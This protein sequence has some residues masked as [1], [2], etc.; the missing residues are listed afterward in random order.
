MPT[1][2]VTLPRPHAA[3][4]QIR[5]EAKRH[6][7]VAL[8]RRSGKSTMGHELVV[9]TALDGQP[10]GWFGPTYKLLEESWRELKRILGPVVTLKSE[11]EHRLE[12][13]GGGT[14]ECW[15]MDT[16]DPARGRKYKRIVVDEAA[17]VPN[18]LDIWNQAL[19][20]TLADFAGESWWLSTPRGLNDFYVLY[21]RGQDELETDWQ[22]WQMPT[23]VNPHINQDELNAARREMPERDYAQEFEARFLQVEGAGVFRGVGAVSRLK[24][25]G[26]TR[27]H[28]HVF[29]VD[30]GRSND[31]TV[32]TVIDAT[33]ME[34]RV[35]DRYSQ[36]EWEFQTERLHKL[37]E[38]FHPLTIVAEANSMGSPLVERLQRG[39]AR[40]I[41][42]PRQ[43]LPVY[44]WTAT[45]ASKAAAI[46]ALSLGIEQG[47]LTLLDDQVQA[48]E[49]LAYEAKVSVTGMLRYSAPPGMHDDC[50]TALS[51]A[52]LGSQHE[53]AAPQSRTHYGFASSRR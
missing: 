45:N 27:G 51:L 32:V 21:Q 1:F 11:Q 5:R 19:R 2:Q 12:L 36:V 8:G 25:Q 34:Q 33:L 28:V 7:V 24:P 6:N 22:S 18:L 46:Q 52:Y 37:A 50:V 35:I 10:A 49:L 39:Y 17:M 20:P 43:P 15:S 41:G 31:Y 4:A 53:R 40:L 48:G 44:G 47:Q 42:A 30:W 16:G 14:I 26:P 29:G 9:R 3:Q 23:S 13:Y 38:V